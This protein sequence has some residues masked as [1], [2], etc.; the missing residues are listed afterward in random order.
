MRPML[1]G[2]AMVML[3]TGALLAGCSKPQ[4]PDK[5]RPVEPQATQLRD[6]MQAPVDQAREVQSKAS[7][8]DEA[9][10]KA[11]DAAGR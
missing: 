7:A 2:L 1:P 4:P 6:A 11:I 10:R 3:M 5:D 9:R 8:A